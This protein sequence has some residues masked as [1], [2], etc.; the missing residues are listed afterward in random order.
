MGR[1]HLLA[2]PMVPTLE[3]LR[4]WR[5]WVRLFPP[6]HVNDRKGHFSAVDLEE[7][8]VSVDASCDCSGF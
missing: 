7:I 2:D 5:S 4:N 8:V 1:K 6:S 3:E